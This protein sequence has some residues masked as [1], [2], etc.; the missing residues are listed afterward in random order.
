VRPC[1]VPRLH[2]EQRPLP[3]M[4]SRPA[5]LLSPSIRSV[6]HFVLHWTLHVSA[7]LRAEGGQRPMPPWTMPPRRSES[8]LVRCLS[9]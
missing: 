3:Q 9:V 7:R 6:T 1:A 4:S 8:A 2:P 5:T